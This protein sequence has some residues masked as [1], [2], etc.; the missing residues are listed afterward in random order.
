[1][2]YVFGDSFSHPISHFNS[3]NE[4]RRSQKE[5]PDFYPLEHN[6][7]NLVAKELTGTQEHINDS[8]AGCANEFIFHRYMAYMNEYKK[9]DYIIVCL[10]SQDRRWLVERCPHLSN[11]ANSK[12]D[13]GVKGGVTK[14]EHNAIHQYAK[15]LHSDIASNAIY[16][17]IIWA[18]IHGAVN[19]EPLGVKVLILPGFHP[20]NGVTGTLTETSFGEFDSI[21]TLD[22]FYKKTNDSRWNHFSEQNHQILANKVC[23]F[24]TDFERVDLTTGFETNIYTKNNI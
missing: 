23:K 16:N 1:M 3:S 5:F 18:I 21:K 2:L 4:L 7:V 17:S 22:T 9:G 10:T 19:L 14:Q 13:P 11:W 24:F 15:Y 12:I 20:I 6:W 8:M